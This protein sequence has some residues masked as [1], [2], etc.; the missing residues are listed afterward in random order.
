MIDFKYR[1]KD[2]AVHRLNPLTKLTWSVGLLV[3]SLLFN[4]PIY[5]TLFFLS[6]VLLVRV[7]GIWRE[8][9]SLMK[10]CLWLGASVIVINALVSHHGAH[11]LLSAPFQLPVLGKLTI[12]LEI[13]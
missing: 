5:I 11:V 12:T 7:S 6:V 2:T 1:D 10:V 9:A 4:N 3:L 8:W 13:E